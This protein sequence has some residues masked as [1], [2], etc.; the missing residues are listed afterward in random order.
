MIS[1]IVLP[2]LCLQHIKNCYSM[3]FV[4]NV[5]HAHFLVN[6]IFAVM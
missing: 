1:C 4:T 2:Q 6:D 5:T 3:V